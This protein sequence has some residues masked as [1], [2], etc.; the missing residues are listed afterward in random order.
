MTASD[1]CNKSSRFATDPVL[2]GTEDET[3]NIPILID[4]NRIAKALQEALDSPE[5]YPILAAGPT[6]APT[7]LIANL[8]DANSDIRGLLVGQ[9]RPM[10]SQRW[11]RRHR[12]GISTAIP[13]QVRVRLVAVE[14]GAGRNSASPVIP[15]APPP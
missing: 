13:S 3:P 14:G 7:G 5:E 11:R 9:P 10:R 12:N 4:G 8:I 6:Q 2:A 1:D 15:Y